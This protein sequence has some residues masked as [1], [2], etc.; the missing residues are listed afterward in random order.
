M[1][2]ILII[3]DDPKIAFA[4]SVRLKAQGYSTWTAEDAVSG[5]RL[6]VQNKPDLAIIDI[7]LPGGNGFSVAEQLNKMP[8]TRGIALIFATATQDAA[9]RRKAIDLG[10][11]G[12]IRKPY[13]AETL[14]QSVKT[15]L[16]K[17]E[18]LHGDVQ[19]LTSTPVANKKTGPRKILIVEDDEQIA[20][21]LAV[22]MQSAG[23]ETTVA[24]D[25]IAGLRK[26]VEQRPDLV[27]LDISMPAGDGFG[28]AERIQLRI[29][30]P[31]PIIFLTASKKADLRKRAENLGAIGFFEKP[32]RA[33]A[34][35]T[36]V[37]RALN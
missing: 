28:V 13:E 14:V 17:Q 23:Y 34:L 27:L 8:E 1:K 20:L 2:K 26:A 16:E 18:F 6:A 32:Y 36:A 4:L 24:H 3:E 29:P 15:V 31:I 21:G 19:Y 12:L 37:Q 11:R 10:A 33:E 25:A 9:L 35:L 30:V 22:R 7:T 5:L